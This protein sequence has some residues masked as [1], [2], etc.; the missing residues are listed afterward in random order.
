MLCDQRPEVP[1]VVLYVHEQYTRQH[2][3]HDT[4]EIDA[5]AIAVYVFLESGWPLGTSRSSLS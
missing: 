5:N 1:Q 4:E 2:S 3:K